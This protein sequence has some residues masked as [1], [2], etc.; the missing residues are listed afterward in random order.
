MANWYP[1]P[2]DPGRLRYWDGSEWTAH[3]TPDDKGVGATFNDPLGGPAASDW[4]PR[5]PVKPPLRRG[6]WVVIRQGLAKAW[7]LTHLVGYVLAVTVLLAFFDEG[8]RL[9]EGPGDGDWAILIA[10]LTLLSIPSRC[11]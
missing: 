10:F 9:S 11:S 7:P 3:V 1:D 8:E 5:V 6:T 2:Q 4:S